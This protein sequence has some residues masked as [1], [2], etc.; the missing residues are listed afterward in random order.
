MAGVGRR[1]RLPRKGAVWG[2]LL[3][4][5]TAALFWASENRDFSANSLVCLCQV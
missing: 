4:S 2:A 1:G 5:C 3:L